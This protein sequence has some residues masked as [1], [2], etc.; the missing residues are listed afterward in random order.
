MKYGGQ[1][2]SMSLIQQLSE[3]MGEYRF[4]P[5]FYYTIFTVLAFGSRHILSWLQDNYSSAKH[6]IL[7]HLYP[8]A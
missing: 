2:V 7:T 8:V 4:F 5:S 6:H 3:L 1:L